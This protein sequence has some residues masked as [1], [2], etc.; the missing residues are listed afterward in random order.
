M[1]DF[2]SESSE[3]LELFLE[4]DFRRATEAKEQ[5]ENENKNKGPQ[6]PSKN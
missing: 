6:S 5:K 2:T 4:A 1:S 3:A